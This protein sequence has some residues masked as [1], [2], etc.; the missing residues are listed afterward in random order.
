MRA[1]RGK[2][3]PKGYSGV[4]GSQIDEVLGQVRTCPNLPVYLAG[5]TVELVVGGSLS[6]GLGWVLST[7]FLL[8][9]NFLFGRWVML[10]A[11]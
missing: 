11:F 4:G 8:F 7:F 5:E 6:R 1:A 2:T 3:V 10:K 9:G